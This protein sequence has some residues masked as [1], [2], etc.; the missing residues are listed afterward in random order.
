MSNDG[1]PEFPACNEANVND[2]MGM[3][4]RDYF[5]GQALANGEICTGQAHEYYLKAWF[6]DR[7]GITREEIAV[8]QAY[9]YADAML[10]ACRG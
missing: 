1:G 10:A 9:N 6:G 4:L 3:S 2:T 5:A 7:G 8:K